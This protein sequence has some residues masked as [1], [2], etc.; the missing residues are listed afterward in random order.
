MFIH[1]L[2]LELTLNEMLA[3]KSWKGGKEEFLFVASRL[4]LYESKKGK[5]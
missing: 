4:P 1:G 3:Q 5:D 2:S